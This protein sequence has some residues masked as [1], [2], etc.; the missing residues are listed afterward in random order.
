MTLTCFGIPFR[1]ETTIRCRFVEAMQPR[2]WVVV[3]V[4]QRVVIVVCAVHKHTIPT[5][6]RRSTLRVRW[7]SAS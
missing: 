5:R 3:G 7:L 1:R 4:G 6:D 2:C